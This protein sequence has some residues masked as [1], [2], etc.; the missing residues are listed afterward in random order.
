ME[1]KI[2]AALAAFLLP[3]KCIFILSGDS[4]A[5]RWISQGLDWLDTFTRQPGGFAK[6][7]Q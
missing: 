1:A 6:K 2:Q 7:R 3:R 5:E 4:S